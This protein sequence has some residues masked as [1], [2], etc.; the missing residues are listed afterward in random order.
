M[1]RWTF[2]T[3]FFFTVR[4]GGTGP[5]HPR[6]GASQGRTAGRGPHE[7]R[8]GALALRHPDR[9][10]DVQR[11]PVRGLLPNLQECCRSGHVRIR[12]S[13]CHSLTTASS[14]DGCQSAERPISASMDDEAR[15]GRRARH[16][17]SDAA[18][19]VADAS[20]SIRHITASHH[21]HRLW[22]CPR[23]VSRHERPS[24]RADPSTA[25]PV[26]S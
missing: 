26:E 16:A 5:S 14:S 20:V 23:H 10:S 19:E 13:C 9:R 7:R 12:W 11:G 15:H 24:P 21:T 2:P 25:S 6:R 17:S 8:E 3:S 18:N 1:F 4:L 22:A